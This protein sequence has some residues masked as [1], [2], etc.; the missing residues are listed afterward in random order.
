MRSDVHLG[1]SVIPS[2][3][4]PNYSHL[5]SKSFHGRDPSQTETFLG[6]ITIESP[7]ELPPEFAH[8]DIP[9]FRPSLDFPKS[10]DVS[11]NAWSVDGSKKKD[12]FQ[13]VDTS[14]NLKQD[15]DYNDR[16]RQHGENSVVLGKEP[17][18]NFFNYRTKTSGPDS[19]S[20]QK[21]KDY[22]DKPADVSTQ[23]SP[24]S[25]P[26]ITTLSR[27]HLP[28]V[29]KNPIAHPVE[30]N[31]SKKAGSTTEKN[32]FDLDSLLEEPIDED[33]YSKH[34]NQDVEVIVPV[35]TLSPDNFFTASTEENL[36]VDEMN[37]RSQN[38][39]KGIESSTKLSNISVN[40]GGE[41]PQHV[42]IEKNTKEQ[43]EKDVER[44]LNE[45]AEYAE[46]D[47]QKSS[48][49]K[50]SN[51][52]LDEYEEYE[53]EETP[54]K[55]SV[56]DE[57][58]QKG[59]EYLDEYEDVLLSDNVTQSSKEENVT[60]G[61][62]LQPQSKIGRKN[63]TKLEEFVVKPFHNTQSE[64]PIKEST[65]NDEAVD[66]EFVQSENNTAAE[67]DDTKNTNSVMDDVNY[68][69]NDVQND[70][71]HE[72]EDTAEENEFPA[73]D[74]P[75]G[76][77]VNSTYDVVT[78]KPSV[79][80]KD[81]NFKEFIDSTVID[82]E[83]DPNLSTNSNEE[84]KLDASISSM[85]NE[86]GEIKNLEPVISVVTTKSVVN[87]TIVGT[88]TPLPTV[89]QKMTLHDSEGNTTDTWVV[90]ASVQT[91][92][93]VSG[94]R[95]L[96]SPIV[97]QEERTKL[98]NEEGKTKDRSLLETTTVVDL[99]QKTET[100]TPNKP[101]TSTESL[102]DK[103]DRVQSDLSSQLLASGFNKNS[104][105]MNDDDSGILEDVT[106]TSTISTSPTPKSIATRK[107]LTSTQKVG[108]GNRKF[109]D[110]IK[111]DDLS[112]LLPA[113]FKPR[114]QKPTT[115][116]P[117]DMDIPQGDAPMSGNDT[118][119]SESSRK[120]EIT[121]NDSSNLKSSTQ[122]TKPKNSLEDLLGKITF[123]AP[124]SL[125]PAGY[126]PTS[127]NNETSVKVIKD[128]VLS[129]LPPGYKYPAQNSTDD[130]EVKKSDTAGK[131]N[132]TSLLSGASPVGVSGFLPPGYKP[133]KE[134]TTP[135]DAKRKIPNL[136]PEVLDISSLL[137]PG[138]KP[139]KETPADVEAKPVDVSSLLPPGYKLQNKDESVDTSNSTA[140][141][142]KTK[143]ASDIFESAVPEDIAKF[144]PPG[145]KQ[146]T[147]TIKPKVTTTTT[148]TISTT[149][150]SSS[151]GFKV[152]FPSRPGGIRK[153]QRLTTPKPKL[154]DGEVYSAPPP[155]IQKGWPTRLV[156]YG[157]CV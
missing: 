115:P 91:S 34:N 107:P 140:E 146:R 9:G 147:T 77:K 103:L 78:I 120:N 29:N 59:S 17:R 16:Q 127:K 55:E 135:K 14:N 70:E 96:P 52:N 1:Q 23:N 99:E 40:E 71:E 53:Y 88:I 3:H 111:K 134:K 108:L 50:S 152:V 58:S 72:Y 82:T 68:E 93:S 104:I 142:N 109:F 39:G 74:Q 5:F 137:P 43:Q 87:N 12:V 41:E 31:E 76:I 48:A 154:S 153:S 126:K 24:T 132:I 155:T 141:A 143:G 151:G 57:N 150:K 51:E 110:T 130:A 106:I 42:T 92:R 2:T 133:P 124:T 105:L 123:N 4:R 138:Y 129:L 65:S 84:T 101:K 100:T 117:F 6:Q 67:E 10:Q 45:A 98:L 54:S 118:Q 156:P 131:T 11:Q 36:S 145:Y 26:E 49:V 64:L 149:T 116:P 94:A 90:I 136:K 83:D 60:K 25:A 114:Y 157:N 89:T 122:S 44:N 75:V 22:H 33:V 62:E 27:Q 121:P 30:Q 95:Y 63:E 102:I 37:N 119:S 28:K 61:D 18:G 113:G 85:G 81:D 79:M 128:D 80:V 21:T 38:T 47:D 97:E 125:L 20:V 35:V 46:E 69:S 32:S 73:V 56:S 8:R 139:P 86:K 144:L 66:G 15:L 148:T 7:A 112:G 13:Y 19:N